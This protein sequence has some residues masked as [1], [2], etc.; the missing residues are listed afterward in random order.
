[1]EYAR[2]VANVLASYMNTI[3]SEASDRLVRQLATIHPTLQQN[4]TRL[5]VAWFK[6]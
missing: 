4:V 6:K 5:C 1:M 3:D 2:E